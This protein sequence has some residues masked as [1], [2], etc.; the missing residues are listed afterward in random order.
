[1]LCAFAVGSETW[2]SITC[3]AAYCGVTGL[4]P[5]YGLL[6]RKG[7]MALCYTMDKLGPL[8]RSTGDCALVMGALAGADP[9][10][11]STVAPPKFTGANAKTLRIGWLPVVEG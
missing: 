2:G 6:S 11:P 9:A 10:D 5:S 1:G 7:A 8:C 4:R 3:P